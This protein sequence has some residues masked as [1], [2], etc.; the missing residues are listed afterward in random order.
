[1]SLDPDYA[2][3][4]AGLSDCYALQVLKASPKDEN[5]QKAT[6][7]ALKAIELDD[8]LAEVH[9]SL[10]WIKLSFE[11][12]WSAAEREFKRAI[13][14]NSN[15]ST[16]HHWYGTYLSVIRGKHDE[17][18]AEIR[19]AQE[20]DP[21]SLVISTNIGTLLTMARRDNEAIIQLRSVVEMDP[22]FGRARLRL[23][24]AYAR[25]GMYEEAV[26]ELQTAINLENDDP[27]YISSTFRD[28]HRERDHLEQPRRASERRNRSKPAD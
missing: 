2:L 3:A 12:D 4:Y 25:K 11:W 15:Y 6:S 1:V 20:L 28:M 14:L 22:S 18:L 21:T 26:A 7:A 19:R 13:E 27:F 17:G 5:Y 16:S 8:T 23:G 10:A 24:D 9:T